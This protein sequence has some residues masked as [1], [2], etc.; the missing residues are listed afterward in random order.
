MPSIIFYQENRL[1]PESI[2]G[3]GQTGL[4]FASAGHKAYSLD[5]CSA[6]MMRVDEEDSVDSVADEGGDD[7][8]DDGDEG[9]DGEDEEDDAEEKEGDDEC[10][11]DEPQRSR[12]FR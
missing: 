7:D 12:R 10:D 4:A 9:H 3:V 2:R 11:G 1:G 8:D 5:F 6:V